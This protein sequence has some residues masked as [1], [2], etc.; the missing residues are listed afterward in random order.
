MVESAP[1]TAKDLQRHI[2]KGMSMGTPQALLQRRGDSL[3][4]LRARERE[5]GIRQEAGYKGGRR[6]K[7]SAEGHTV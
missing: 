2:K 1:Q 3:T 4:R 6:Q 7:E 5:K